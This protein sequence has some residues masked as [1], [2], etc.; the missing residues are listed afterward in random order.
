MN[1]HCVSRCAR[2]F[3]SRI[4][5]TLVELL[6]VIAVISILIALLLPAL[7]PARENARRTECRNNTRQIA[8]M[9]FQFAI[10][11][12]MTFPTPTG[13]DPAF[14]V[15]GRLIS[16][17]TADSARPLFSYLKDPELFECPSD[18]GSSSQPAANDST[19]A[20]YGCSYAYP[21]A[22]VGAAG[23][24]RVAGLKVTST[25]F[26][27]PSRKVVVYEPPLDTGNVLTDSRNLW[28]STKRAS[29]IG[30]M[31][32]HSELVTNT[33]SAVSAGN[34]YY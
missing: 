16:G 24:A 5:F 32:G 33:Y 7:G 10:D 13:S 3:L 4:G 27:L 17:E 18:R 26:S 11:N 20:A 6:V 19:Y 22:D 2:G 8:A 31:D 14:K 30:F 1:K 9:V 29:I 28:H 15:G 34:A 25:N 21:V 23:V 12:K